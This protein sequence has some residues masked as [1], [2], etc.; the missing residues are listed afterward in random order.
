[1][2]RKYVEFR[3][4]TSVAQASIS[5]NLPLDTGSCYSMLLDGKLTPVQVLYDDLTLRLIYDTLT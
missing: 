2:A 3:P 1:M 5:K 4:R